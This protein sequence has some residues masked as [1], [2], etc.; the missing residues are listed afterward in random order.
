[1]KGVHGL[2]PLALPLFLFALALCLLVL[3]ARV[4]DGIERLR[5]R[6]RVDPVR[7]WWRANTPFEWRT[8]LIWYV[9]L[10]CG[11]GVIFSIVTYI[12]QIVGG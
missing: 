4:L 10:L 8:I 1:M 12:R 7:E 11:F 2:G 9:S 5:A 3:L 6:W